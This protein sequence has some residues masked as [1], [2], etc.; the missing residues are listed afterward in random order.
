[1]RDSH[2]HFM[3]Q[4]Y[5][6][7]KQAEEKGEV[8][9]AALVVFENKII[10]QGFNRCIQNNDPTAH[11]EIVA[12]REAGQVLKNYRLINASLYVTLEPC[13]MC[14]VAMIHARIKEL[15]FAAYDPKAGA[16]SS[17]FEIFNHP[18]FNHQVSWKGGVMETPCS[19]LLK[20]F[21]QERRV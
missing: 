4:A 2:I 11:A 21:F 10:G 12:M 8:P 20:G 15:I 18:S 13:L 17:A 16:V 7:A 14:A 5:E 6:L 3:Q 19:E 9:V 1:M